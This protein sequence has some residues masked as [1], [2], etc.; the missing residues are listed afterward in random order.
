MADIRQAILRAVSIRGSG[1]SVNMEALGQLVASE[2]QLA[3]SEEIDE[4]AHHDMADF[5]HAAADALG[6]ASLARLAATILTN[7]GSYTNYKATAT[8]RRYVS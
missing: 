3:V 7:S 1:V 6:Y 2:G 5:A 8:Y 4:M